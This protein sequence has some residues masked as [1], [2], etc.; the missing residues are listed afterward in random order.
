MKKLALYFLLTLAAA[1][2]ADSDITKFM[3][4]LGVIPDVI[5]E[6]PDEYLTVST[7][8]G[9]PDAILHVLFWFPDFLCK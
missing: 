3:K 2:A 6:G 7:E 4:H 9:R 8:Q 5:S 1:Y